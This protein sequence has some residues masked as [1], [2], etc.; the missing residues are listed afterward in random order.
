MLI[1][2]GGLLLVLSSILEFVLGNTFSSVVFG[3]LGKT[4]NL[5]GMDESRIDSRRCILSGI[6]C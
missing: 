2:F 6:R 1:L 5:L 4:S 3:H